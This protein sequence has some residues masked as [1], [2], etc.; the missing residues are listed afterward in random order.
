M[1][2]GLQ[3]RLR[4][5]PLTG[6]YI[7]QAV[8]PLSAGCPLFNARLV[9]SSCRPERVERRRRAASPTKGLMLN[10]SGRLVGSCR[11]SQQE[12]GYGKVKL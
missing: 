5:A 11:R 2:D 3:S 7:A 1:I 12:A 6:I 10:R 8:H 4:G 9:G